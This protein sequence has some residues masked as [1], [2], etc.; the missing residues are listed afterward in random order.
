VK[1]TIIQEVRYAVE[2]TPEALDYVKKTLLRECPLGLHGAGPDGGYRIDREGI[3]NI[4]VL[5]GKQKTSK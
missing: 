3:E 2:C 5:N 4:K 1:V